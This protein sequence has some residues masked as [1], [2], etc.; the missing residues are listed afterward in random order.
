MHVEGLIGG[1]KFSIDMYGNPISLDTP[2][3]NVLDM[4]DYMSYLKDYLVLCQDVRS[5]GLAEAIEK[6][7]RSE[8]ILKF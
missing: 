6:W 1:R 5:L 7:E 8:I 2:K 3:I 4:N